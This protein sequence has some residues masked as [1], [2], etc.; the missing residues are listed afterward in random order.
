M[1]LHTKNIVII[2]LLTFKCIL[3]KLKIT[4]LSPYS[5]AWAVRTRG[6]GL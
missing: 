2:F 3:N 5:V 4:L 6:E 1:L